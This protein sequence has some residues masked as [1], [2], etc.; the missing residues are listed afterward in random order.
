MATVSLFAN[1]LMKSFSNSS[2][3]SGVNI[4]RSCKKK[5][6]KSPSCLVSWRCRMDGWLEKF[7]KRHLI[8]HRQVSG[9]SAG[10][11]MLTNEDWKTRLPSILRGDNN[12]DVYNVDET[13]LL[14]KAIPNE[15]LFFSKERYTVLVCSNWTV[16]NKLKPRCFKNLNVDKRGA[17]FRSSCNPFFQMLLSTTARKT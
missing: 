1:I 8:V 5:L 9:E 12:D 13:G 16:S 2:Q 3:P 10:V 15:S 17:I 4:F 7:R 11:H 6:A 14:L